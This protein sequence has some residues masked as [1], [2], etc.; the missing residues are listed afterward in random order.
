MVGPQD[1][2]KGAVISAVRAALDSGFATEA[3]QIV[4]TAGVPFNKAGTTNILRVAPCRESLIYKSE[5]E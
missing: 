1:R 2:F 5:P 3:D 4:V